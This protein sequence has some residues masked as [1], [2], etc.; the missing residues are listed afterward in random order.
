MSDVVP[1]WEYETSVKRV[2]PLVLNWGHLSIEMLGELHDA[3]SKLSQ[4]SETRERESTGTFVSVEH[5][6]DG[7]CTD[8]GLKKRTANRWLTMYDPERRKLLD[9][10]EAHVSHNSGDN[11]W[12]T[13]EFIIGKA[14][15]VMGSIDLDPASTK[16]ANEIVQASL[17]YTEDD[18]GLEQTW[19]GNVWMN[20]PY[21]KEWINKFCE[22]L[23]AEFIEGDVTQAIVL[24]N[25]GTETKWGQ[26]IQIAAS[27]F[28]LP[29][30]RIQF[31]HPSKEAQ[32]L[33]GQMILYLGVQKQRFVAEFEALGRVWRD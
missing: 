10:P 24:V 33:Q 6:W 27:A 2:K 7:Y 1:A 25:N 30:G 29:A 8:V 13:P 3:R 14:R 21:A 19:A 16:K 17:I 5:S 18:D 4:Q 11:E 31:W 26:A 9:A 28:C 12:Y 15:A 23:C 20:P 22:K 32:P